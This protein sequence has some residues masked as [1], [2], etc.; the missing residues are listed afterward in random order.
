MPI[1]FINQDS[2]LICIRDSQEVEPDDLCRF[3]NCDKICGQ[4]SMSKKMNYTIVTE[5]NQKEYI[6]PKE[7]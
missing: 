1:P 4:C 5:S 2:Q 3:C 6:Y 7:K